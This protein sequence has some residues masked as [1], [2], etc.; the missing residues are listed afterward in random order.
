MLTAA[1]V[2]ATPWM[3]S[4]RFNYLLKPDFSQFGPTLLALALG[5]IAFFAGS[6]YVVLNSAMFIRQFNNEKLHMLTGHHKIIVD[7]WSQFWMY[8]FSNSVVPGMTILVAIAA[9]FGFGVFIKN[10]RTPGLFVI[11]CVLLFYLPAE[12]V[13][14]KPPP[15]PERYIL[16]CIPFMC[17][18][19][20]YF[21]IT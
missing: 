20:A 3:S 5:P 21:I 17:L 18:A 1:I 6:P 2:V 12:W 4:R 7:P 8:H 15:Q 19:A 11:A 9:L 16:P 10:W 13:N 14:A